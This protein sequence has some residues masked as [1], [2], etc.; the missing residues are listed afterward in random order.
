MSIT[1]DRVLHRFVVRHSHHRAYYLSAMFI[2]QMHQY[3]VKNSQLLGLSLS[4]L[5]ERQKLYYAMLHRRSF[6]F[7]VKDKRTLFN[8]HITHYHLT[9]LTPLGSL[10]LH[11]KIRGFISS[12]APLS[13]HFPNPEQL[14]VTFE[15]R[16]G[17]RLLV[18][19]WCRRYYPGLVAHDVVRRVGVATFVLVDG[20]LSLIKKAQYNTDKPR[21]SR[22][23]YSRQTREQFIL[24]HHYQSLAPKLPSILGI[25]SE[26]IVSTPSRILIQHR[27]S[28]R[29]QSLLDMIRILFPQEIIYVVRRR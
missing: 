25:P 1:F 3:R 24:L 8:T 14:R 12:N 29:Q 28:P 18:N 21:L 22:E 16:L 27:L 13:N 15:D 23:F 11:T 26:D 4:R 17:L 10:P 6:W 9:P 5:L 7:I 2:G 19:Q 20:P